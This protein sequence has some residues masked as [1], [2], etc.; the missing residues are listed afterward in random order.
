[1]TTQ[2]RLRPGLPRTPAWMVS[3]CANTIEIFNLRSCCYAHFDVRTDAIFADVTFHGRDFGRSFRVTT[4]PRIPECSSCLLR[5]LFYCW[6]RDRLRARSAWKTK[7]R[8]S[9]TE[10]RE[11]I[12]TSAVFQRFPLRFEGLRCQLLLC[13][14]HIHRRRP[15]QCRQSEM[16]LS[17]LCHWMRCARDNL[18][19]TDPNLIMALMPGTRHRHQCRFVFL[20][21]QSVSSSAALNMKNLGGSSKF[22]RR[23]IIFCHTMYGE[24]IPFPAAR[25]L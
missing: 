14:L 16:D 4:N 8:K 21:V 5:S 23:V 6:P 3:R 15:G 13:K 20:Y 7:T 9:G 24:N 18:S 1:M 12:L 22:C 19:K 17:P 11:H 2:P 25:I 10:D